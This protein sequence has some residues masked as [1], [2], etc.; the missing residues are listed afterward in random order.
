MTRP[1]LYRQVFNS[2]EGREVFADICGYVERMDLSAA[3]SAGKLIA[4][5]ARMKD[6]PPAPIP[7]PRA[8]RAPGGRISHG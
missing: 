1:D 4:H 3:G 6:M 2:P 7:V 5:M 8:V